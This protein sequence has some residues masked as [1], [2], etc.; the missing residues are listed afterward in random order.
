MD[1]EIESIFGIPA[2]DYKD[3]INLLPVPVCGQREIGN[4]VKAKLLERAFWDRKR[5]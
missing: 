5:G 2:S 3:C 4:K 1:W